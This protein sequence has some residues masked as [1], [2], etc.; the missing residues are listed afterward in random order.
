MKKFLFAAFTVVAV[1][2]GFYG[3][4]QSNNQPINALVLANIEA[5]VYNE[6]PEVVIE[7]GKD[8]GDCWA[9]DIFSHYYMCGEYMYLPCAFTGSMNDSCTEPC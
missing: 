2:S 1:I 3:Y 5:L 7:C 8:G 9:E 4:N 6:L